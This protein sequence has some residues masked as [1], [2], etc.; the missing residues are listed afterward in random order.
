LAVRQR[1]E[2]GA[3]LLI[4]LLLLLA[5]S[6]VVLAASVSTLVD[7]QVSGTNLASSQAFFA[8]EAGV[9]HAL[10]WISDDPTFATNL[11]Q[12]VQSSQGCLKQSTGPGIRVNQT[13]AAP[14]GEDA[15]TACISDPNNA[16][17]NL[18]QN[19]WNLKNWGLN[20][21]D[22]DLTEEQAEGLP[23]ED[24]DGTV[25]DSQY[26]YRVR[27]LAS[28]QVEGCAVGEDPCGGVVGGSCKFTTQ[29]IQIDAV[30][31]SRNGLT[32]RLRVV[33]EALT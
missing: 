12:A 20:H 14:C 7:T 24:P 9:T 5:I 25:G 10:H 18:N 11:E 1:Q 4:S 16:E 23:L 26:W 30:G 31:R 3:I 21:G 15:T 13:I 6:L 29:L 27:Y 32:R 19:Y 8:A 2:G 28:E 33:M 17:Y 22:D